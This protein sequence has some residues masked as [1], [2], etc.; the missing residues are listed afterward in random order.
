MD[1]NL[2]GVGLE[3]EVDV[4]VGGEGGGEGDALPSDSNPIDPS[5]EPR[6]QGDQ[7]AAAA[8]AADEAR[9]TM[10]LDSEQIDDQEDP[11]SAAAAPEDVEQPEPLPATVSGGKRKRGRPRKSQTPKQPAPARKDKE[12]EEV[13]FICFDGG[14]LVCCDRRSDFSTLPLFA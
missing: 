10:E 6:C 8:A 7:I 12:E 5:G 9:D 14:N 1:P 4:E 2:G 11:A 3:V 13:C